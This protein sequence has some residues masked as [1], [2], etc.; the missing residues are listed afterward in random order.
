MASPRPNGAVYYQKDAAP[1]GVPKPE[2]KSGG[3]GGKPTPQEAKDMPHRHPPTPA[4]AVPTW[5]YPLM[6]NIGVMLVSSGVSY[7]LLK[8]DIDSLKSADANVSQVLA[9]QAVRID[10]FVKEQERVTRLEERLGNIATLLQEI[11]T[12]LREGRYS[13]SKK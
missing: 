6:I 10:S 3:G 1:K 8:G 13:P 2:R 5:L 11:R 9:T 12:D 7:G 4:T